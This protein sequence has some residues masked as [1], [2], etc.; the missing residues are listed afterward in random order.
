[1]KGWAWIFIFCLALTGAVQYFWGRPAKW[2][3]VAALGVIV[4]LIQRHR[5]KSYIR[6]SEEKRQS[7]IRMRSDHPSR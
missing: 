3:T 6:R 7:L 1:V 4:I 5:Q 2:V